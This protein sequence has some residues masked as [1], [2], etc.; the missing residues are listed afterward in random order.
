MVKL[1]SEWKPSKKLNVIGEAIDV[2]DVD[3]L[4][5][6]I[7]RDRIEESCYTIRTLYGEYI[8]EL[9]DGTDLSQREAQAWVLRNLVHEGSERLTYEAI[10]LYIW[11]IG[12]GAEGDPLSRTIVSTYS[13]RAEQKIEAAEETLKRTGP[14]PYPDDRL[15]NPTMLWVENSVAERLQSRTISGET[16][17]ETIEHL[18]EETRADLAAPE[19][20]DVFRTEVG[21]D[22]CG[23]KLLGDYWDDELAITVHAPTAVD[24][25]AVIEAADTV[26]IDGTARPFHVEETSDPAVLGPTVVLFDEQS[27]SRV[28]SQAGLEE[29]AWALETVETSL[30]KVIDRCRADRVYAL[31]VDNDPTAAGAHLYPVVESAQ[32]L[33]RGVRYLTRIPLDDRTVTVGATTPITPDEYLDTTDTTLLWAQDEGPVETRPLPGAPADRRER[34]PSSVL[35]TA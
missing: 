4:P 13:E 19:L 32:T 2:G 23:V 6:D 25:P 15:D 17:T 5:D 27:E 34:I 26:V 9:T 24:T 10:G 28:E 16:Y 11:A 30:A 7:S 22:Y 21:I 1:R 31:A 20:I 33:P 18:L 14:P 29:L 8:D 35:K 12:R 3:P